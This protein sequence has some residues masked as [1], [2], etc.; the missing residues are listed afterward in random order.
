[1][2]KRSLVLAMAVGFSLAA[3]AADVIIVPTNAVASTSYG[4]GRTPIRAIDGSGLSDTLVNTTGDP[5]PVNWEG[6]NNSQSPSMWQSAP[7]VNAATITFS[8]PGTVS[9]Q[10]YSITGLHIWNYNEYYWTENAGMK[11]VIISY[12]ADGTSYTA[13]PSV[14]FATND[15]SNT[16]TGQTIML[17]SALPEGTQYIKFQNTSN[18]GNPNYVGLSEVRFIATA[19]PEPSTLALVGLGS[20]LMAVRRRRAA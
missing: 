7:F 16:Y 18:W 4:S 10:P 2:F 1:M 17:A 13:L 20:M 15:N 5:V 9:G 8:L 3:Q 6:H 11:D 19:I 12:S 14:Q